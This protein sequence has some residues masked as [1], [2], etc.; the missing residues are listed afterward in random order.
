MQIMIFLVKQ[1]YLFMIWIKIKE[2][3]FKR[4]LS[5][6]HHGIVMELLFIIRKEQNIPISMVQNI[7]IYM[8]ITLM[9][10]KRIDL[11]LIPEVFRPVLFLQIVH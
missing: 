1:I 3:V 11:L 10:K 4:M 5:L 8:N 2:R 7:M 6:H 9:I